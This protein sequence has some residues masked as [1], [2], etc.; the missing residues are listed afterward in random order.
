MK[1]YHI[2]PTPRALQRGLLAV[3]AQAPRP[4]NITSIEDLNAAFT[5]FKA[6]YDE[7][8][9]R[10]E[11][12]L[13]E[14][15][16]Q[17]A[18][19]KLNGIGGEIS[20]EP[21]YTKTFAA[22]FQKG[23][24]EA[25]AT[26][27]EANAQGTRATIQAAMSVGD[28]SSGGYLAPVEWD[29][30]ILKEQLARSPMRRLA[31]VK[32]T[33]VGAYTT[34]W[35][36]GGWGSG[37]VGETA[38][39]PATETADLRPLEF[40]TG[41]IYAE[42]AAT[43]RLLD[44]SVLNVEDWLATELSD[45]FDRQE[46]I[47]FLAGDGVNKPRGLLTYVTGGA[48]DGQHP[49]GNIVRF[50]SGSATDIPTGD[51]LVDFKYQLAAPYRQNASWLMN[52]QTAAYIAKMKDGQGNYIW[53]EGLIADEPPR[54]LGRPVE[55]DENM[56]NIAAAAMPIAFGDFAA[57]YLINDR[58]GIRVLRDPFT[59][60][61]FVKFYTTKRVGGGVRDPRAIRLLTIATAT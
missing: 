39:R 31:T 49:G 56:P 50:N 44:D 30:K 42:P 48:S 59:N 36:A 24:T 14:G 1:S 47:A 55:I 22:Y 41:E 16:V 52:S 33:G 57:G 10:I 35:N 40:A 37:W 12:A 7:R 61:P 13:D 18:A 25:E 34:L 46:G 20:P 26:L 2:P 15:A 21:E 45:E 54:L 38:A 28:N 5:N 27:K 53:R 11:A 29:R 51:T 9:N 6:H 19:L 58:I 8:Q 23:S 32:Q 43:Q 4:G 60:K 3:R 17:S